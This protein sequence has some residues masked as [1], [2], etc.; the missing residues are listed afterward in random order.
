[1][2]FRTFPVVESTCRREALAPVARGYARDT[3][4]L[5]WEERL[6]VRGRR[7]SDAGVE[8]GTALPRGTVLRAGDCFV[9]DDERLTIEVVEQPEA[10]FVIE[11][12]SCSEWSLFAYHIGNGHQPLMITE[13]ALVCPD[14]PGAE[15][16]LQYH[17]IPYT[18]AE[19]GF[20]PTTAFGHAALGAG[21]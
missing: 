16:L 6:K 13:R 2:L 21:V 7:R 3:I 15:L 20:T 1:M 18:R 9:F 8:F 11:P 4:T 14:V 5:G 19:L 12:A 17:R 10:V